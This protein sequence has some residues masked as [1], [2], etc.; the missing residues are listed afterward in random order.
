MVERPPELAVGGAVADDDA[1][2]DGEMVPARG[3]EPL[4]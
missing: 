3:V 1:P 2:Q 4:T